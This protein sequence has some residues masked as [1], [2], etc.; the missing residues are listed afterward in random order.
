[1]SWM[2]PEDIIARAA[3]RCGQDS[4]PS[5]T[6]LLDLLLKAM[7]AKGDESKTWQTLTVR[8]TEDFGGDVPGGHEVWSDESASRRASGTHVSYFPCN[9]KSVS[10]YCC[11]RVSASAVTDGDPVSVHSEGSAPSVLTN[12]HSATENT[13]NAETGVNPIITDSNTA[14][15]PSS[16]SM[17][18]PNI[19]KGRSSS[20]SPEAT[21]PSSTSKPQLLL[22]RGNL[23]LS[24][25]PGKKVRVASGP[26]RGRAAVCRDLGED[27]ARLKEN[28]VKLV[29]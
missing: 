28:G 27:F 8:R 18:I 1:M 26:V 4:L 5:G 7:G 9:G 24:S 25:C 3:S 16:P 21:H 23:C 15:R 2:F 13:S 20:R 17:P 11:V 14:S 6:D 10:D 22:P 12:G 29:V 19:T